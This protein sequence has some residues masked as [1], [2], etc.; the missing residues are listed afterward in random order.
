MITCAAP[1]KLSSIIIIQISIILRRNADQDQ[2]QDPRKAA[3]ATGEIAGEMSNGLNIRCPRVRPEVART[4][5]R[6]EAE[7]SLMGVAFGAERW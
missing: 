6:D 2:L 3:R 7:E 5:R 1:D 4:S